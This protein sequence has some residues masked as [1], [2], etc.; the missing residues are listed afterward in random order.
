[1]QIHA[2]RRPLP[3]AFAVAGLLLQLCLGGCAV[4][5]SYQKP[6]TP[7][8]PFHSAAALHARRTDAS[9]PALES[10]WD[11]F[12]DPVLSGIVR[13]ARDQNL[14]LAAALARVQEARAAA[15]GAGAQLLPTLDAN[16]QANRIHQSLES[17]IGQ[18][19]S[20]VPGFGRDQSLYDAGLG[21]SW[22]LD[23]FGGLRRGGEA[24]SAEFDAA[25]AEQT[26]VRISVTA[27][28]ADAYLRIRGDQ[29]RIVVAEQQVATDTHLLELVRQ[30]F[31]S[32]LASVREV[33]QAEALMSQARASLQPLHIDLE[34][35][36]NRL[37]VL[38]GVQPGTLAAEM[39]APRQIPDVPNMS[40]DD[41]PVEVLRRRPDVIAAE[42]HLAAS[43][44]R[45]GQTLSEYYP[46][47]SLAGV[48]GYES[49][50]PRDLFKAA[51]FQPQG[52]AGLRWRVFDFG[53]VSAEVAQ[54]KGAKAEALA[55]YQKAV[56]HAAE[57]VE[58]AFTSLVQLEAHRQQ[59]L[60]E[61]AALTRAP[62]ASQDAYRGGVIALTDVLDADRQLLAAQDELAQTRADS[63]RAA[64]G[65]FRALGGGW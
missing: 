47:I 18:I 22:E 5:P 63:A 37:D 7:L 6:A 45:I 42:R 16:A 64:V 36:M 4:G 34:A 59:L 30:R 41:S 20:H 17:P 55:H 38:L 49:S 65:T 40:A 33:A 58:D 54:A 32:G 12:N 61:V 26:G 53:K 57:E 2:Q 56:L 15:L 11:G 62:D 8:S 27:D 21:A 43:N 50:L 3:G 10:W 29:A 28:A 9:P 39:Q 24:A 25:I 31:D 44:A 60:V 52:V 48:L 51:T 14:D 19:A 35:Q 1:M 23:L 46:K 13:R